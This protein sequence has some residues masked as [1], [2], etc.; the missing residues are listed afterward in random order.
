MFPNNS[1]VRFIITGLPFQDYVKILHI[2]Q[3]LFTIID[4]IDMH[5]SGKY[6]VKNRQNTR[7]NSLKID[8]A[9]YLNFYY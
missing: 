6:L 4:I 7:L 2:W 8:I 9:I 5:E 1:I 3:K